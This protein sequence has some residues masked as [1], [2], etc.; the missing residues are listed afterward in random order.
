MFSKFIFRG[1]ASQ[2]L[3]IPER[4]HAWL[5]VL[6][7]LPFVMVK[8]IHCTTRQLGKV[9]HKDYAPCLVVCVHPSYY[10]RAHG[11]V[12]FPKLSSLIVLKTDNL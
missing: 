6:P 8:D 5:S 4:L 7:V 1:T 3:P 12:F 11:R 9:T 2:Y 10:A